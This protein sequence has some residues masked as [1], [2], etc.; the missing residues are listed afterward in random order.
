MKRFLALVAATLATSSLAAVEKYQ[1]DPEHTHPAF[2]FPH[3]G[4]SMWRGQFDRTTG[5]ITLDRAARTGTVDIAV[6]P[7]SI[8]FGLKSMH[9]HATT[10]DWL[11]V[12]KFPTAT[13][14][15]TIR[16][17]G[18]KPSSVEGTLVFRGMTKPLTLKINSFN[19]I[20]HP[21]LK[22]QVCG[23]DAEAELNWG[24]FGMTHSQYAQ[25]DAGRTR[26][27]IQVEA[28]KQD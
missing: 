24:Q 1:V 21:M 23:A 9:E 22:K 17:T 16:F 27:R 14:K 18:D 26:L 3:M 20:P 2:E 25:G 6:D 7:A 28:L 4:I 8:N 19:C 15:G 12:A 11:D 13:Y 10:A 5:T